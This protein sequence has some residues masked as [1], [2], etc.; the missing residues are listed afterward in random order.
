MSITHLRLRWCAACAVLAAVWL[1]PGCEGTPTAPVTGTAAPLFELEQLSGGRVRFPADYRGQVV[2]I[3]FW[4][5][6]CPYCRDEMVE[7]EPVYHKYRE[8]GLRVLAINV[9]QSPAVAAAFIERLGITYAVLL[10]EQGSVA[11]AY[12]VV[13]LPTTFFIDRA[14]VLRAR[15]LGEST[16]E[17][18]DGIVAGLL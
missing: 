6:W 17:A 8:R 16:A 13:G 10:D 18:F 2:A 5:D 3:R 9:R 7:I 12:G 4:A 15:I 11:R 1:L 14:G